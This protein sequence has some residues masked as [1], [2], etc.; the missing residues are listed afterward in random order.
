MTCAGVGA[1]EEIQQTPGAGI[2]ERKLVDTK[3]LREHRAL[4]D[5]AAQEAIQRAASY[6]GRHAVSLGAALHLA[7]LGLQL[8]EHLRD[9][10]RLAGARGALNL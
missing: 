10:V 5:G 8:R 1:K 4:D 7:A 2:N 9:P 6:L 3:G